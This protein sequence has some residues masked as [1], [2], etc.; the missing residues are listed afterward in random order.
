[1]PRRNVPERSRRQNVQK[2]PRRSHLPVGLVLAA[3]GLQPAP[4]LEGQCVKFQI[5]PKLSQIQLLHSSRRSQRGASASAPLHVVRGFLQAEGK[6]SGDGPSRQVFL[7]R[8][9][10]KIFLSTTGLDVLNEFHYYY[11]AGGVRNRVHEILENKWNTL[12]GGILSVVL[13]CFL[14]VF[15][16]NFFL[17]KLTKIDKNVK[18]I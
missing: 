16:F 1:M 6:A 13:I 18:M 4:G 15:C 2:V 17:N 12:M 10:N 9:L 3:S 8:F 5:N 7:S 11:F 14:V